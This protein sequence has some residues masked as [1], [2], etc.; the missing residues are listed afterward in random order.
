M[1][2]YPLDIVACVEFEGGS[3]TISLNCIRRPVSL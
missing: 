2:K 3:K 1:Q